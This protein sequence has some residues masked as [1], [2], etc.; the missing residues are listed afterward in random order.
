MYQSYIFQKAKLN[1]T[2]QL[3]GVVKITTKKE[4]IN[5]QRLAQLETTILSENRTVTTMNRCLERAL[6]YMKFC[7]K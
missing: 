3:T 4:P 1:K 7:M 2:K 6:N 5:A